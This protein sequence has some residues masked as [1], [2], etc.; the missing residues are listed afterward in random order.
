MSRKQWLET[1]ET[2]VALAL[3]RW[4]GWWSIPA[5][6]VIILAPRLLRPVVSFYYEEWLDRQIE[7]RY[8]RL[9]KQDGVVDSLHQLIYRKAPAYKRTK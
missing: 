6:M 1:A 2:I 4:I 7:K 5:W 3:Y 8:R 9:E